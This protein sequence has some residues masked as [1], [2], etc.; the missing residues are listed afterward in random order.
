LAGVSALAV[1]AWPGCLADEADSDEWLWL[2]AAARRSV[3]RRLKA[4]SH[5][6]SSPEEDRVDGEDDE[7]PALSEENLKCIL[8]PLA[9]EGCRLQILYRMHC[10][11]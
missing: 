4:H 1:L 2:A 11:S 10:T 6:I 9:S 3:W 5:E 8:F 7:E